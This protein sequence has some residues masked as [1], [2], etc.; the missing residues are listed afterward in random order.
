MRRAKLSRPL[1]QPEGPVILSDGTLA[2]VEMDEDRESV[3]LIGPDGEPRMLARPGGRPTGL[4]L[5]GDGC[6]WVAGGRGNSLVRLD[7]DGRILCTIRGD[8]DGTFLFPNDLA[9]GP[10]GFLY[11]TDSGMRPRELISGLSIRPDFRTAFYAGTVFRIDPVHG[12]V[13]ERIA[14]DLLFANGIAFDADGILH[15]NE[16]LTGHIYRKEPGR[17]AERYANVLRDVEIDRFRGP[18]GMAFGMD[19]HLYCAVYGQKEVAVVA[20]SGDLR[21][22][23]ETH[24]DRPTNVVFALTG[25][26]LLVTEVQHGAVEEFAVGTTGL[27]L[28]RPTIGGC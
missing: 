15:Y 11:M 20:P 10:D 26:T 13:V 28:H 5:D 3:T 14:T 1:S 7:P 27:P 17:P 18:D 6:L 9:F 21:Q 16:T 25:T 12:R 23:I 24:G 19:G 8:D 4:A 22:P 2:L